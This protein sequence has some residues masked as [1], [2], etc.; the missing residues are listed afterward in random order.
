VVDFIFENNEFTFLDV[1]SLVPGIGPGR[2]Q[3]YVG[4]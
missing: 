3:V 1:E 4:L 2:E